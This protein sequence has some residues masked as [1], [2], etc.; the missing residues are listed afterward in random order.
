MQ[1]DRIRQIVVRERVPRLA[2]V[3][4]VDGLDIGSG[5]SLGPEGEGGFVRGGVFGVCE[6]EDEPAGCGADAGAVDR[7]GDVG[8]GPVL[9]EGGGEGE[10]ECG[11]EGVEGLGEMHGGCCGKIGEVSRLF[12]VEGSWF[13][14][15]DG[16]MAVSYRPTLSVI[17]SPG[18]TVLGTLNYPT[19]SKCFE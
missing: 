9:G 1:P 3:R 15:C 18:C 2:R 7:G 4:A 5:G 13:L 6:D 8:G 17:I 16:A 11:C 14:D 10:E 19:V 12:K